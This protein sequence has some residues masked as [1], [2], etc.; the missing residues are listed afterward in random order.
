MTTQDI[1]FRLLRAELMQQPFSAEERE[2]LKNELGEEQRKNLF[3]LSKTHDVSA[4]VACALLD[5]NVIGKG[6]A[7]YNEFRREV[8][9]A[10]FRYENQCYEIARMKELF[11][12]HG[13]EHLF[14]KGVVLRGYYAKPYQR[15][16]CDIDVLIKKSNLKKVEKLFIEKLGYQLS[17]KKDYHDVTLV[18][19]SKVIIELHF[20]V[21]EDDHKADEILT[22]AWDFAQKVSSDKL[23]YAFSKEFMCF[24]HVAHAA[25]HFK[26]GGCGIKPFID[27]YLLLTNAGVDQIKLKELLEQSG[28]SKFADAMSALSSAWIEQL[29]KDKTLS[30]TEKYVLMGGCYGLKAN[31]ICFRSIKNGGG[32]RYVF[33]RIFAP[34][35]NLKIKY[36]VIE[37]HKWLT[38]FCHVARWC[39]ALFGKKRAKS[40]KELSVMRSITDKQRE[41]LAYLITEL[42]L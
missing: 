30:L 28:L 12:S 23:E 41:E 18:A 38:P 42:G 35:E 8:S 25:Y 11:E 15:T 36:P 40:V 37:K 39:S 22:K 33:S 32:L 14:L 16:C 20:S 4:M 27:I 21:C 31:E 2:S 29:P 7:W 3:V 17:K 1:L 24:Y 9:R 5:N 10:I 19:P 26:N 34:Y 13:I 6:E